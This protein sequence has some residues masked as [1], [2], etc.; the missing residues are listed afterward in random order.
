[1]KIVTINIPT[2]EYTKIFNVINSKNLDNKIVKIKESSYEDSYF[3]TYLQNFKKL[4]NEIVL[5]DNKRLIIYKT[6]F[7]N[8]VNELQLE[9]EKIVSNSNIQKEINQFLNSEYLDIEE[10][11]KIRVEY[12]EF[13][14]KEKRLKDYIFKLCEIKFIENNYIEYELEI[15]TYTKKSKNDSFKEV[16]KEL[17]DY[18]NIKMPKNS[19]TRLKRYLKK[20]KTNNICSDISSHTIEDFIVVVEG[21]SDEVALKRVYKNI[22]VYLT[23]GLGI[24]EDKIYNLKNIANKNNKK[25]LILTDPDVPGEIIRKRILKIIPG[26]YNKY[27]YKSS[28]K[29]KKNK[30]QIGVESLSEN[31]IRKIFQGLKRSS[32]VKQNYTIEN[33]MQVGIYQN[34]EKREEFCIKHNIS[35]GNNKKVLKQLNDYNI[36]I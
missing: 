11:L 18:F 17:N 22:N 13:M 25:V 2:N 24:T 26:A 15:I 3:D 29:N 31:E 21:K 20:V 33:L 8:K 9:K 4:N 12:I 34:K 35:Y 5:R 27:I 10:I 6:L 19:R 16:Y 14:I 36:K 28:E 7:L 30:K 32:E 23:G 1:M